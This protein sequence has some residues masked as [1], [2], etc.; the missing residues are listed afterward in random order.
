MFRALYVE[1]DEC[2][3]ISHMGAIAF[4]FCLLYTF[5]FLRSSRP[6]DLNPVLSPRT[7]RS[8]SSEAASQ[9]LLAQATP[10]SGIGDGSCQLSIR[11]QQ[12]PVPRSQRPLGAGALVC[13]YS[14]SGQLLVVKPLGKFWQLHPVPSTYP[15]L[16]LLLLF[17]KHLSLRSHESHRLFCRRPKSQLPANICS[18][19]HHKRGLS[20]WLQVLQVAAKTHT[21]R[22]LHSQ[23]RLSES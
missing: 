16:P 9:W 22:I 18:F 6:A 3:F 14:L 8:E 5:T 13:L 7:P 23:A 21:A 17:C 2:E 11:S 12:L 19:C 10:L 4:A 15:G 1:G 20:R